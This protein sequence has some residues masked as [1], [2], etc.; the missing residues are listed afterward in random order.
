MWGGV[1]LCMP[2][3]WVI[4]AGAEADQTVTIFREY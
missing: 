1:G 3:Y 4:Q 2:R